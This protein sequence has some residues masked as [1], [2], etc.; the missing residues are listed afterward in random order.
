MS[1]LVTFEGKKL[2]LTSFTYQSRLQKPSSPIITILVSGGN[3][4]KREEER[5]KLEEEGEGYKK[6]TWVKKV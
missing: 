4:S 6:S 3:R 1:I 2:L 5:R